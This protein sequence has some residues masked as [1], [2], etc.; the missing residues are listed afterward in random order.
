MSN[1]VDRRALNCHGTVTN[2]CEEP[3]YRSEVTGG[4]LSQGHTS[5]LI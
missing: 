3:E 4:A 5:R 1:A 2:G